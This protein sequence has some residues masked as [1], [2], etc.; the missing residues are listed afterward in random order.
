MGNQLLQLYD[1]LVIRKVFERVNNKMIMAAV[2][3]M[4]LKFVVT[5]CLDEWSGSGRPSTSAYVDQTDEEEMKIEA[6]FIY[7]LEK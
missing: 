3:R 7:G 4:F 6:G 5:Y 2:K 1:P